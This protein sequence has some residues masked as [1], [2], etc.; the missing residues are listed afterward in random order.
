MYD[1]NSPLVPSEVQRIKIGRRLVTMYYTT[2]VLV[3]MKLPFRPT[4]SAE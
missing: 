4:F 3:I 1:M 2:I